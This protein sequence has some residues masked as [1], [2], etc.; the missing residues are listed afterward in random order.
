MDPVDPL[1]LIAANLQIFLASSY[2]SCTNW[3]RAM[4]MC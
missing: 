2:K 3:K 1:L 4:E